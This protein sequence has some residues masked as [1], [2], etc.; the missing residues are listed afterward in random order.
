MASLSY[1]SGVY[2]EGLRITTKVSFKINDVS[3]ENCAQNLPTRSR[4]RYCALTCSVS[5][6]FSYAL[7]FLTASVIQW[8]DFLAANPEAP[9]SI[10]GTTKFSA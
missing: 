8:S 9:S 1:I 10:P 3:A 2:L 4:N 7:L 5:I 6:S